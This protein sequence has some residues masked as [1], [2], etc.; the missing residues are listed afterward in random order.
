MGV[1]E[2]RHQPKTLRQMRKILHNLSAL[3]QLYFINSIIFAFPPCTDTSG[4]YHIAWPLEVLLHQITPA[5]NEL[6][7]SIH[8]PQALLLMAGSIVAR[9]ATERGMGNEE[10]TSKR[11]FN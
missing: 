3:Q 6:I 2:E 7:E 1:V 4:W 5:D 10:C 8:L 11:G 9:E